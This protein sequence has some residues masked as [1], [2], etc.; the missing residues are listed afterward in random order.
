ML[1]IEAVKERDE[2]VSPRAPLTRTS[3]AIMAKAAIAMATA[4][5]SRAVAQVSRQGSFLAP[6]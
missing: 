3:N 1:N 5:K 2:K 6:S 4:K